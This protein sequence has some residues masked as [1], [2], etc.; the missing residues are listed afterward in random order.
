MEE[1]D[2][3]FGDEYDSD[4]APCTYCGG[5]GYGI[6]GVDWDCDDPVNGPYDGEIERCPNCRGSGLAKDMTFW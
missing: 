1:D 5:D 4:S 6:I 2:Y 3:L